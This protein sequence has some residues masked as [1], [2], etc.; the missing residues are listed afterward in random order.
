MFLGDYAFAQATSSACTTMSHESY[1][2]EVFD[3]LKEVCVSTAPFK[4]TDEAIAAGYRPIGPE[5]PHMGQHW[6]NLQLAMQGGFNPEKPAIL[7]Y[8]TIGET[9]RLTG[10]AYLVPFVGAPPAQPQLSGA[11]WHYHEG[12]LEEELRESSRSHDHE[13]MPDAGAAMFHAWIWESNPDGI[14]AADNW[15]LPYL[16]QRL[17]PSAVVDPDIARAL[18]MNEM[19]AAYYAALIDDAIGGVPDVNSAYVELLQSYEVQIN[20]LL[21][22][23]D[24]LDADHEAQLKQLWSAMWADIKQILPPDQ[25]AEVASLSM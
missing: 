5:T 20:K 23:L 15:I 11:V 8:S 24:V 6:I 12:S 4:Q 21:A 17:R 16:Q 9:L 13:T 1:D 2:P 19:G 14:F 25:W 3:F 22:P 7:T 18:F 10:V